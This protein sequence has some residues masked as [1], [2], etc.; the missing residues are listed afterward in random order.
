ME[1]Q[2]ADDGVVDGRRATSEPAD[3]VARPEFPEPCAGQRE[4]PDEL[5]DARV[6]GVLADRPA[7]GPDELRRGGLPVRVE[8]PFLRIEQQR[9]QPVPTRPEPGVEGP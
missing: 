3:V 7:E 9:P 2:L 6:A 5:D 1:L 8:L 4:L